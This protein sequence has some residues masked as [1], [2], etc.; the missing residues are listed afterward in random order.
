LWVCG[1]KAFSFQL[2]AQLPTI[3]VSQMYPYLQLCVLLVAILSAVA[4]AERWREISGSNQWNG[5]LDPLDIEVRRAVIRYGELAQAT[6]DAFIGDLASPYAGSSRYGP[7][8]FFYKVQASNP[9]E[10]RVTRFIYATSSV[11]LPDG[12]MTSKATAGGRLEHGVQLDGVRRGGHRRRRGGA[13]EAGHRGGVAR[14]EA[15]G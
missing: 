5:L 1:I 15:D 4:T 3:K 2:H 14:D 6:S 12:F 9:G 8:S 10:Y 7:S 11:R 13:R